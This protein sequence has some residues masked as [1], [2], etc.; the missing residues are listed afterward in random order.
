MTG[1]RST[2]TIRVGPGFDLSRAVCSYGYFLLAPNRWDPA[3]RSL[4]RPLRG[5][6]DR[7]IPATMTQRQPQVVHVVCGVRVSRSEAAII[8]HQVRRMLRVGEDF[9]LWHR[10][11]PDAR[12]QR[13]DRLFRSPS[14]FED[15][16]KT[17]TSCNVT[18]PN[19]MR[20]NALL[21]EQIGRGAF[22]TPHDLAR[23]RVD[24]LKRKCKVGYRAQ[25]IVGLARQVVR[26]DLNLADLEDPSR[27]TDEVFHQLKQIHGI[28]DFAAGNISHLLGRYDRL[29]IDSET[30]RHFRQQHGI[31]TPANP[32]TIHGLIEAHYAKYRPYQ[33][34]AYWFE[35]WEAYQHRFGNALGWTSDDPGPNFTAANLK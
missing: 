16:V 5:H 20:M 24:T 19:T 27:P 31:D 14:L 26:G 13:F 12:R 28:G 35:L 7:V 22:P 25:R 17:I 34:L 1:A 3:Q 30:Y 9:S 18:W 33:F 10:L 11:H 15:I 29:A 23:T 21:C 8:R 4:H 6:E 32:K 2:L